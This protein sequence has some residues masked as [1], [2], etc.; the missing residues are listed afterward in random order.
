MSPALS[1][2]LSVCVACSSSSG[3]CAAGWIGAAVVLLVSA[4]T[5]HSAEH[6]RYVALHRRFEVC[7]DQPSSIYHPLSGT[8]IHSTIYHPLSVWNYHPL[9]HLPFVP[10]SAATIHSTI[11]HSPS[12]TTICIQHLLPAIW[13]LATTTSSF[14]ELLEL[15]E[16]P[17]WLE[18]VDMLVMIPQVDGRNRGLKSREE[19]KRK[20]RR[21]GNPK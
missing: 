6:M 7:F 10:L 4:L 18:E 21:R 13:H 17:S 12:A 2:C 16:A 19:T 3:V 15:F 20:E 8:T 5:P 9:D 11:Y 1:A 14:P